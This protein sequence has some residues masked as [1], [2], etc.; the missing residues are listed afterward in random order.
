MYMSRWLSV[1][2]FRFITRSRSLKAGKV[3]LGVASVLEDYAA[4]RRAEGGMK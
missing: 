1:F 4:Q 3:P 2:C